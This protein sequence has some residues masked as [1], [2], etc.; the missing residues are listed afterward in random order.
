MKKYYLL[1][2]K[3]I[4]DEED[5]LEL[6]KKE[7]EEGQDVAKTYEDYNPITFDEF[8]EEPDYEVLDIIEIDE[9]NYKECE[10]LGELIDTVQGAS[11]EFEDYNYSLR[12]IL[13]TESF[14]I[15]VTDTD[16]L[17]IEFEILEADDEIENF[18]A[19]DVKVK[20]KSYDFI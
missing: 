16:W 12:D 10:T 13:N 18:D 6:R 15:P 19:Y 14:S 5:Y 2:T 4:L 8:M 11:T 20:Y 7:Y 1:E 9:D 17:N 3:K